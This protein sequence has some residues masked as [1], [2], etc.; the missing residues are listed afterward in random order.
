VTR[1]DVR[2]GESLPGQ[3]A[4][5]AWT[6]EVRRHPA[7]PEVNVRQELVSEEFGHLMPAPHQFCEYYDTP[8]LTV[9][10]VPAQNARYYDTP[11][12]M[13]VLPNIGTCRLQ[14]KGIQMIYRL[15]KRHE[16]LAFHVGHD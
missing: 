10:L 12:L 4:T 15:V 9:V 6:R 5:Q 8:K 1:L 14:S 16:I 11:K 13:M 2:S 3:T 7:A